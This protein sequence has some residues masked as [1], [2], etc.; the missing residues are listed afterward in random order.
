M[1]I[2][3]FNPFR[4][5]NPQN[6]TRLIPGSML[7]ILTNPG[8]IANVN[9]VYFFIDG[10]KNCQDS[11]PDKEGYYYCNWKIPKKSNQFYK[12]SARAYGNKREFIAEDNVEAIA[13]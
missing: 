1:Y 6:G 9:V 5:I 7:K 10:K 2:E 11:K 8:D 4:I 13:N 3:A 12:I